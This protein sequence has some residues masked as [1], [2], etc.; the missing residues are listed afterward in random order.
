M[1]NQAKSTQPRIDNINKRNWSN[2]S[3]GKATSSIIPAAKIYLMLTRVPARGALNSAMA[4][5]ARYSV[6]NGHRPKVRPEKF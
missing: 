4:L 5:Y 6:D 2:I 3:D 1:T